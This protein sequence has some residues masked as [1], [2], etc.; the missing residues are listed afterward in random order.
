[1]VPHD[2]SPK[3]ARFHRQAVS[4]SARRHRVQH[5][6]DRAAGQ[7][8][9][10]SRTATTACRPQRELTPKLSRP[11][12]GVRGSSIAPGVPSAIILAPPESVLEPRRGAGARVRPDVVQ[13]CFA[14]WLA[15][16]ILLANKDANDICAIPS[17]RSAD[18]KDPA[19]PTADTQGL[20]LGTSASADPNYFSTS[21]GQTS[22]VGPRPMRHER[23]REGQPWGVSARSRHHRLRTGFDALTVPL[24][25]PHSGPRR[26]RA[27]RAVGDVPAHL[28]RVFV[29]RLP[30]PFTITALQPVGADNSRATSS[31]RLVTA[32]IDAIRKRKDHRGEPSAD[33]WVA[34]STRPRGRC[35]PCQFLVM[36]ANLPG[37]RALLPYL[38]TDC[39][40]VYRKNRRIARRATRA[41]AGVPP[42]EGDASGRDSGPGPGWDR[43]SPG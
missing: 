1:M 37:S 25:C 2:S 42:A 32:C 43:C 21:Q 14:S 13:G 29:R 17:A 24:K 23:S 35:L 40:F 26:P 6:H 11:Q 19:S 7:A 15:K 33:E 28:P 31:T 10:V 18:V 34:P 8:L 41:R 36:G 22:P 12:G 38:G 27:G 9:T 20:R 4:V 5:S 16:T 3:W 30:Q 39:V